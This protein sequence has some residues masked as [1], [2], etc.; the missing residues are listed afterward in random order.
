MLTLEELK[1]RRPGND[2]HDGYEH[3]DGRRDEASAGGW[4]KEEKGGQGHEQAAYTW[5]DRR[6]ADRERKK[7]SARARSHVAAKPTNYV[8]RL[9]E[10][11]GGGGGEGRQAGKDLQA[12]VKAKGGGSQEEG[13]EEEVGREER[14]RQREEMTNVQRN[15]KDAT[16]IHTHTHTHT[17]TYVYC[18]CICMYIRMYVCMYVCIYDIYA[19]NILYI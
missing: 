14:E 12:N 13:E 3:A 16:G 4:R 9:R 8:A 2:V 18:I 11:A 10:G 7:E 15:G 17:H 1:G 5:R 19:H 6:C